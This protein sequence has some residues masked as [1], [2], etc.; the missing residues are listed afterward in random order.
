L[1]PYIRKREAREEVG[2]R[3]PETKP[4]WLGSG[5]AVSN[6]EGAWCRMVVVH[7]ARSGGGRGRRVRKR[8]REE[9]PEGDLG[10]KAQNRAQ[11]LGFGVRLCN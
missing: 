11:G 4:L 6:G 7:I 9:G 10:P 8:E 2:G 1:G 3:N 5:P